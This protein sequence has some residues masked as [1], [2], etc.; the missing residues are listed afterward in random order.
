M[1]LRNQS[2]GP[3][4]SYLKT[5]DIRGNA[6]VVMVSVV[7]VMDLGFLSECLCQTDIRLTPL[8]L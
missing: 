3:K 6:P 1:K 7:V 8:C 2:S 5:A 4:R